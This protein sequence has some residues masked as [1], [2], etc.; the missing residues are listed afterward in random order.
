MLQYIEENA[1][2]KFSDSNPRAY[3]KFMERDRYS[4]RSDVKSKYARSSSIES[5]QTALP[6]NINQQTFV[7]HNM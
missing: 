6:R 2:K 5:H 4:R 7:M 3:Q 1:N